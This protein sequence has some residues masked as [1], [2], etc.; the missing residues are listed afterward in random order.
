L[1]TL[2]RQHDFTVEGETINHRDLKDFKIE[3]IGISNIYIDPNKSAVFYIENKQFVLTSLYLTNHV[4]SIPR[5]QISL[6]IRTEERIIFNDKV[7]LFKKAIYKNSY[8]SSYFTNIMLSN[9][10]IKNTFSTELKYQLVI[11][12]VSS[13][14]FPIFI[15]KSDHMIKENIQTARL[16][17][18]IWI[19]KDVVTFKYIMKLIIDSRYDSIYVCVFSKD[20]EL[21]SLLKE[22]DSLQKINIIELE[23][24]PSF[25]EPG[26][27]FRNFYEASRPSLYVRSCFGVPFESGLSIFNQQLPVC[28]RG[29][30]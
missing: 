4:N 21:K 7:D 14:E 1:A 19:P 24:I 13:P 2:N 16:I 11:N 28:P 25:I 15:V 27:Y 3:L 17:K 12:G 9:L 6:K 18:C 23:N 8:Y 20:V 22:F 29:G 10:N 5:D 26:K 30:L